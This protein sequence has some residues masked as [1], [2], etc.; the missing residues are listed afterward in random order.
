MLLCGTIPLLYDAVVKMALSQ[1]QHAKFDKI[2]YACNWGIDDGY[3]LDYT[4]INYIVFV[5]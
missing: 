2:V 5:Y 1:K 4:Y 3:Q